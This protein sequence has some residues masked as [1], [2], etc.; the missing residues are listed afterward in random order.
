[1]FSQGDCDRERDNRRSSLVPRGATSATAY[2]THDIK[3]RHTEDFSH[4]L[5]LA[6]S[7]L[8]GDVRTSTGAT[9]VSSITATPPSS[10]AYL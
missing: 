9:A 4:S 2:S 7:P 6:V 10:P 3:P 1:M 8:D 5:G